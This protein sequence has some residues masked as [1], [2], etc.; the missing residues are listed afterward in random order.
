[1]TIFTS[2]AVRGFLI[3]ASFVFALSV[4]APSSALDS[5]FG[6]Q[7][8]AGAHEFYVWCTGKADYNATQQG[9][10]ARVAQE[11]LAKK[12][13]GRCWPVWQGLQN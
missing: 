3:S 11:T 12:A 7:A 5:N 4:S 1:M 2:G 6:A 13:G 8:K 10:N 9:D